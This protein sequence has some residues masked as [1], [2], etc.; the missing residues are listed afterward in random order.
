AGLN[1]LYTLQGRAAAN[2]QAR[3]VRQLFA[4]DQELVRQ[5]HALGGGRWNHQ[6]S[7]PKMGYTYW[8]SPNLEAAP[9]VQEVHPLPGAAP[10]IAIE[11][12]EKSWPSYE[13]GRA[14]LPPL[15]A[16]AGGTRWIEVFNRGTKSFRFRASANQPWIRIAPA[17]AT[18][19]EMTRLEVGADWDAVPQGRTI[20][21][22]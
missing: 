6:M 2:T 13:A 1:R 14:V 9:A 18:V 11:G 12:S 20:A 21:T 5:Y 19:D 22:L 17:V 16:L 4:L 7:Q 8:Q 10:A 15:H 3:R